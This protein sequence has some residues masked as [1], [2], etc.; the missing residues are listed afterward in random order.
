MQ[1]QNAPSAEDE[2]LALAYYQDAIAR[3]P[4]LLEANLHRAKLLLKR[5]V[6]E[7]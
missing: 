1:A 6:E 2:E 7:L 3:E 4:Y 5:I